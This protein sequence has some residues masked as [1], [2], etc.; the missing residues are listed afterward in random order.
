MEAAEPSFNLI[1]VADLA[2]GASGALRAR[3]VD[4]E[5]LDALLREIGPS[6]EVPGGGA[7]S[8]LTF[9][10]YKDFR[11]DRLALRVPAIAKLLDF[12]KGVLALASGAGSVDGVRGA[13]KSLGDFPLLARALEE[14]LAPRS[15]SPLPP[16]TAD[17]LP[18][19]VDPPPPGSLFD[20]VNAEG[21]LPP[22]VQPS[23][24]AGR[25]AAK[26]IDAVLGSST[27]TKPAPAA[28]RSF[29]AQAETALAPLLRAVL[30]D[31]RFQELEAAWR[32]LRYLVRSVD[33][34]SA[35]R[36]HVVTA[37]RTDLLRAVRE[38]VLP[39]VDDLRSGG[40]TSCLLLDF[41]FDGSE[42]DLL[43]LASEASAHSIPVL[44]S[45]GL[46]VAAR[47]LAAGL[48][49]ASQAAWIRLRSNPDARWIALAANRFLLRAPYGAEGDPVK[50][51]S[52]E[53]LGGA[54]T[55][56][57]WG[58]PGWLLGALVAASFSRTGWGADFSGRESASA[59]EPLPLRPG[60]EASSPLETDLTEAAVNALGATGLLPMACR[61]GSDRP[62]AAGTSTVYRS[63]KVEPSSTLR[64]AFFTAPIAA[65]ME[66]LLGH[67]DL[68]CSIEEI[69]RTIGAALQ[70]MGM[71]EG[72]TIYTATALPSGEGRPGVAVRIHPQGGVLRGLPDLAFEVPIALH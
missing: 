60:A 62:F 32:G 7:R 1:V 10:D 54:Q 71:T 19:P 26:L 49:D 18:A 3:A 5:T 13:L 20:L 72:G 56:L 40:K 33:F 9:Q 51:L 29:A 35:C 12:K 41:N 66:S 6:I 63:G 67:I 45:A 24:A 48:G 39:L 25:A 52:F 21:T 36:V 17:P 30:H 61:R 15:A 34:R 28:L 46:E 14:A 23:E 59:L 55:P 47:D 44:A 42:P 50:D 58:R 22:E 43:S 64:Y 2:P 11:P 65:A 27:E 8:V 38:T 57:L 70:I 31:P 69:A 53:E 68:T 37:P 4:K 16:P